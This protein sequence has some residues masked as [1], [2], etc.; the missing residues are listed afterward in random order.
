MQELG[1]STARQPA[2]G[3]TPHHR[4]HAQCMNEDCPGARNP[5]FHEFN[6][7]FFFF[8][9][10]SSNFSVSSVFLRSVMKLMKSTGFKFHSHYS[11]TGYAIGHQ[12]VRKKM[13][14]YGWFC[15]FIFSI[16]I[17]IFLCCFIK[18]SLSQ[19]M[20]FTFCPFSSPSHWGEGEGC[21]SGCL[22][23]VAGY[24]VKPRQIT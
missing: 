15:I 14:Q 7:C 24:W 6:I 20:S 10:R 21:A 18:L 13:Y 3:N 9:P 2:H 12:V 11:R 22:V 4:C 19:P 16:S 5:L 23:L 17:S 8:F 1:G